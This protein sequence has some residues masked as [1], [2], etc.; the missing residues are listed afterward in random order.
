[1]SNYWS[2]WKILSLF[3]TFRFT[4]TVYKITKW[5][6]SLFYFSSFCDC[7][8][9]EIGPLPIVRNFEETKEDAIEVSL[10]ANQMSANKNPK[11]VPF[12]HL[13]ACITGV[14]VAKSNLCIKKVQWLENGSEP[15]GGMYKYMMMRYFACKNFLLSLCLLVFVMVSRFIILACY[16]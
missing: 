7:Y 8:E 9:A 15:Q 1:M 2:D 3:D 6:L 11:G 12:E 5:F 10:G 16:I 4:C 13:I 14:E